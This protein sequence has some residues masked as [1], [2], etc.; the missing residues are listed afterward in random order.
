M[1]KVLATIAPAV[2]FLTLAPF[3]FA[4]TLCP[5]QAGF[6]GLCNASIQGIIGPLVNLIFIIAVIAA[7]LYLIYGGF[8][9]LTSGGD[10]QAVGAA[11]DHII[12]AI[13]G[14][15]V[16]FLSYFILQIVVRFFIPDFSFSGFDLPAIGGQ[17]QGQ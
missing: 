9:W 4:E 11:R 3:A 1:K 13:I 17:T 14:L 5:T 16:I 8:R 12:A 7:L 2:G 15:V 6:A 10:K